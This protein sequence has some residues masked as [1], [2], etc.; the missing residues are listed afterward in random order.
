MSLE[1]NLIV[2]SHL[3]S[4]PELT[5]AATVAFAA[6]LHILEIVPSWGCQRSAQR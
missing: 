3:H 1:P 5:V 6:V 2:T 4:A